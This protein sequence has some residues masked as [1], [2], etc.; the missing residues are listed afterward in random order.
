M[1]FEGNCDLDFRAFSRCRIEG[2]H[3]ADFLDSFSHAFETI[4]IAA[5]SCSNVETFAIIAQPGLAAISGF[6]Q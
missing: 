2:E 3:A 5:L 4:V 6:R 1:I